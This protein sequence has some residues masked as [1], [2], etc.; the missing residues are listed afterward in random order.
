MADE[1]KNEAEHRSW[2][3]HHSQP[4]RKPW[5]D[6]IGGIVG[7]LIVIWI[8]VFFLLRYWKVIPEENWW[9]YLLLGFGGI[10]LLGGLIRLFIARWRYR[11]LGMLIPGVILSAVGMI[12]ITDKVNWWP[13]ILVAVGV[14]IVINVL[15]QFFRKRK[16]EEDREI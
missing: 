7:G 5:R 11:G 4:H 16:H 2:D 1:R 9:A 12:F 13:L 6:P 10:F 3:P 14:V 15:V 8:G